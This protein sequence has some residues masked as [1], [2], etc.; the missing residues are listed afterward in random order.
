MQFDLNS[1]LAMA[2]PL[3]TSVLGLIGIAIKAFGAP[4][5]AQHEAQVQ[6]A[7]QALTIAGQLADAAA[8]SVKPLDP[9]AG[10]AQ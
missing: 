7:Q 2:L 9:P 6:L 8:K 1:F 10:G 4:S 3:T 5:P